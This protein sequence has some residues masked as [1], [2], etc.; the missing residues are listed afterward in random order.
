MPDQTRIVSPGIDERSV[1]SAEGELL[2]PPDDWEKLPPA[3][4]P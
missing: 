4:P 2:R 3:T 1:R